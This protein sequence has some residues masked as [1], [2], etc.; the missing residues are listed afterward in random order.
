VDEVETVRFSVTG[1]LDIDK[2]AVDTGKGRLTVPR[3][4]IKIILFPKILA[5]KTFDVKATGEW[6]DTGI[7]LGK[8]SGVKI[9]TTGEITFSNAQDESEIIMYPDGAM[10]SASKR[11]KEWNAPEWFGKGFPLLARIGRNGKPFVLY[12]T[13]GKYSCE[14]RMQQNGNLYLKIRI[15]KGAEEAAKAFK[16]AYKTKVKAE[17]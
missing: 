4:D 6:L 13:H 16:G 1:K 11:D 8:G 17:K 3:K 12:K 5:E 15:P 9:E 10:A 7:Y 14:M 2:L